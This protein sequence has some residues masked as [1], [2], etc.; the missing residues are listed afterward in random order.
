MKNR[1]APLR[2]AIFVWFCALFLSCYPL[3]SAARAADPAG[4]QPATTPDRASGAGESSDPSPPDQEEELIFGEEEKTPEYPSRSLRAQG[5]RRQWPDRI[6]LGGYFE[7]EAGF[8]TVQENSQEDVIDFRSKIF[9]YASYGFSERASARLSI[10]TLYWILEG[11]NDKQQSEFD[12]YEGYLTYKF[13]KADLFVG[14]MLVKW[15][16]CNVFSPTDSVN[17]INYRSFI[18]PDSEDLRIPLPMVKTNIYGEGFTLEALYIPIFQSSIFQLTGSDLALVQSRGAQSRVPANLDPFLARTF[19]NYLVQSV[20]VREERFLM[21]E[22]AAKLAIARGSSQAEFVYFA[23][24]EDFPVVLYTAPNTSVNPDATG[25]LVFEFNRYELYGITYKTHLQ[26]VDLFT[27]YAYSPRRSLTEAF[28]TNPPDGT[29][30]K[31]RR[32]ERPWQAVSIELDYLDPNGNYYLKF[33]AERSTY[34]NA[35]E[36]L[37]LSAADTK[38]FLVLVRLFLMN[39]SIM[40][41]WRVINIQAGSNQWFLSPRIKYHFLDRYDL[42]AGLNIFTGAAGSQSGNAQES[43][44]AVILSDNNQVFVSFRWSF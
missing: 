17:P 4:A 26:G 37:L 1:R 38:Y 43:T 22:A 6:N 9:A 28:D 41:E 7:N 15:G 14:Q 20:D 31:T 42:I 5:T 8:D 24:R 35:P 44:P 12:L 33:G 36:N 11:G 23:T 13:P 19:Q 32:V 39:N 21:G 18:D 34:F 10:L 3:S 29:V 2:P 30:D 25:N 40:P 16:V 27:E